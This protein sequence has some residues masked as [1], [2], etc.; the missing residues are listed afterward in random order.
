MVVR[1]WVEREVTV[2]VTSR[3]PVERQVRGTRLEAGWLKMRS[4][5]T[6]TRLVTRDLP[7][8][9]VYDRQTYDESAPLPFAFAERLY[10]STVQFY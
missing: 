4:P 6:S 2:G 7:G 8:L 5:A 9:R 1:S 3:H 10:A